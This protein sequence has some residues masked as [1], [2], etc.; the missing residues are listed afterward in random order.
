MDVRRGEGGEESSISNLRKP[1]FNAPNE[2]YVNFPEATISCS[3]N[4]FQM[5]VGER[6]AANE[7]WRF[8]A[9]T[10]EEDH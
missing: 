4:S 10:D 7:Q 5:I 9:M 6:C 3:R 8:N 1:V 2:L